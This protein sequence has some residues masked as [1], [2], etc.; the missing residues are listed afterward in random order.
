MVAGSCR[1]STHR[2][3]IH[4]YSSKIHS[5]RRLIVKG[6]VKTFWLIFIL[7]MPVAAAFA[8]EQPGAE[9]NLRII[10][11]DGH[12]IARVDPDQAF[13][14]FAIDTKGSTAQEAGARN[15][16]IAARVIATLKSKVAPG[17]KV[18]TGGYSLSPLYAAI[19]H[20]SATRINSW[21]ASNGIDVECDPSAAG[22]L[23]D[24]AQAAGAQGSSNVDTESGSG[25]ARLDLSVSG[26]ALTAS[27]ASALS[28]ERANKVVDLIKARL[29]GKGTVKITRGSV[30]AET[31]QVGNQTPD[32]IGYQA[33]NSITVETAAIDQVGGLIDA[34]I[35]AGANRANFVN[36]NLRDDSR[37]RS[38]A[39]ADACKEA[40]LKANA[41]AQALGLKIKRVL[42]ITSA[43]DFYPQQQQYDL[44]ERASF[45]ASVTATTPIRPGELTVQATVTVVY[46]LE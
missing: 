13:M 22:G 5:P 9:Q 37:A 6:I 7:L 16:Q 23:L 3:R 32:I 20:P 8:V 2:I 11:V 43:G 12:G 38:E 40:Q 26:T 33:S 14:S 18:E 46:E 45:S 27:A 24:A 42:K 19:G 15:A 36:F 10:Q 29:G 39:I 1:G 31:E 17:G 41:A 21:T 28:A 25:R 4:Y 34:A 30:Q 35:A 44:S